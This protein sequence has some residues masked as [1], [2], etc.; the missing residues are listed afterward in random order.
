MDDDGAATAVPWVWWWGGRS[1]GGGD[2]YGD[3]GV[4]PFDPLESFFS[5]IRLARFFC[6]LHPRSG[7]TY[8]V[9]QLRELRD[10]LANGY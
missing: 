8:G 5:L 1:G 10:E 3:D 7:L 9:L 2:G 4:F 6:C